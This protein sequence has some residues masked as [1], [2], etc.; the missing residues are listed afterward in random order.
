MRRRFHLLV[1]LAGLAVGIVCSACQ[2][3]NVAFW[4]Q[5]S[6]SYRPSS[7]DIRA[8]LAVWPAEVA[9]NLTYY[10]QID[11]PAEMTERLTEVLGHAMSVWESA[12]DLRFVSV[13]NP[14]AAHLAVH[15]EY[16]AGKGQYHG[17]GNAWPPVRRA[18]GTWETSHLNLYF[19]GEPSQAATWQEDS[20]VWMT[21]HELGHTLGLWH[22][23]QRTDRN[24]YLRVLPDPPLLP[25]MA[26]EQGFT[27]DTPF[28]CASVM[29]YAWTDKDR[30]PYYYLATPST[31]SLPVSTVS[32][33]QRNGLSPGDVWIIQWLYGKAQDR[34]PMIHQSPRRDDTPLTDLQRAGWYVVNAPGTEIYG[35]NGW[36]TMEA[37]YGLNDH[38]TWGGNPPRVA[39]NVDPEAFQLSVE[40]KADYVPS[41]THAGVFVIF[42][43]QD[44][45]YF[46]PYEDPRQIRVQCT[47]QGLSPALNVDSNV[48]QLRVV[49][50]RAH[51]EFVCTAGNETWEIA[52]FDRTGA[53]AQLG[54]GIKTWGGGEFEY[55]RLLFRNLSQSPL[56]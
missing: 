1:W 42:S 31:A 51:F 36:V 17:G 27:A 13:R 4:S 45:I 29:M 47:G 37:E 26:S 19:S 53:P 39:K 38:W 33:Y 55:R 6:P 44:W 22:E 56:E 46:G 18:D 41:G 32:F 30:Q 20:W 34:E 52:A 15:M 50:R 40:I 2:G 10:V 8:T 7:S 16:H 11:A 5:T 21:V 14:N 12:A 49:Y 54:V 43:S 35:C 28:D 24:Q 3:A 25:V 9:K 48:F 23:F